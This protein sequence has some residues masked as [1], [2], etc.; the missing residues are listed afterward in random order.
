MPGGDPAALEQL[1][2]QLETAAGGAGN[3]ADGTHQATTAIRS[4]AQWSGDAAD[5]YTAFTGNLASGVAATQ[6]PLARIAAAVRTYA[7]S[8]RDAQQKVASY[9]ATVQA[10]Q[11]SGNDAAYADA[12]AAAGQDAQSAVD[13]QQAAGN[14]A[15]DE[16]R[17]ATGDLENPFGPDGPV[18]SWI[19]RIHAP[20]DS[21]A[22]DAVLGQFLKAAAQGEEAAGEAKAFAKEMPEM[23][24]KQ[25]EDLVKPL[26][27][28]LS[29]GETSEGELADALRA[30]KGDWEAIG[31]FNSGFGEA[32]EAAARGSGVFKGIGAASDVLAI[33]GD[34]YTEVKPEDGGAMGTVDRVVAGVN[35]GL[36]AADLALLATTYELPVVGEVALVGTGLYLGADYLYHH[37]T[38]FR[39][40]A[41]DVGHDVAGAAK[42]A[43]HD[44]TS[45]F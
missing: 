40:V 1:A 2:A 36:S 11:A 18:R 29:R 24:E 31:K 3:L 22:G 41:N 23:M 20:W 10:A 45:I 16:V 14:A 7:G 25:F 42:G 9:A 38:P 4:S 8:L 33:A 19:E 26:M 32:G 15:A 39:N 13:A 6:Q 43:W 35:G 28:G 37:W 34:V 27:S 12:L 30:F 5:A 44:V 17:G 21:L